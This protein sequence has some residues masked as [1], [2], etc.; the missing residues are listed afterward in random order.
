MQCPP[1][2]PNICN[3]YYYTVDQFWSVFL[4][5]LPEI[6]IPISV[7][8]FDWKKNTFQLV[9]LLRIEEWLHA[10]FAEAAPEQVEEGQTSEF[11]ELKEEILKN[12]KRIK[13]M[14]AMLEDLKQAAQEPGSCRR[15]KI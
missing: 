6:G 7:V 8:K 2:P 3:S 11:A 4:I 12:K 9:L 13:S 5:G 1:S 14:M 15:P 10:R